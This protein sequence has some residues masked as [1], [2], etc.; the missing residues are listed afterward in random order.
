MDRLPA[1]RARPP[2]LSS[3]HRLPSARRGSEVTLWGRAR[4]GGVLPIDEPARAGGTLGYELMCALAQRVP[5]V[6]GDSA[7]RWA[8]RAPSNCL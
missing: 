8:G 3:S 4:N 6:V 2:S 1:A 5:V 7:S